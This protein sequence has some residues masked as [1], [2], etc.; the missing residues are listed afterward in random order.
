MRSSAILV[1]HKGK[2]KGDRATRVS[3]MRSSAILVKL[4]ISGGQRNE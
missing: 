2:R 1:K 4:L 3:V